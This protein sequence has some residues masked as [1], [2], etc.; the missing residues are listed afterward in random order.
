[1]HE[2]SLLYRYH[3]ALVLTLTDLLRY[4][5]NHYGLIS[6]KF[7]FSIIDEVNPF[8]KKFELPLK[9]YRCH[10]IIN[11]SEVVENIDT[12]FTLLND[13]IIKI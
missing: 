8:N 5:V 9:L 11:I 2:K 4:R 1:M 7:K 13:A 3:L 10:K 12:R 6:K